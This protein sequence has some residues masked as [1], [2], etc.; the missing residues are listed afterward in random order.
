ML[1][2]IVSDTHSNEERFRKVLEI[3]SDCDMIIHCGDWT[4]SAIVEM[5]RNL[6][7]QGVYGNCDFNLEGPVTFHEPYLDMTID[8]VRIGACHGHDSRL[9]ELLDGGFDVVCSGHTHRSSIATVNGGLH[10]NPGSPAK[11]KNGAS[12]ALYDTRKRKGKIIPL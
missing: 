1:I 11:P 12:C 9:S 10:I 7:V 8:G 2:G 4:N 3:L 6:N 5:C